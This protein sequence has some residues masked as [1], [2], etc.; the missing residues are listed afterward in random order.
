MAKHIRSSYGFMEMQSIYKMK[1]NLNSLLLFQA[2]GVIV[3]VEQIENDVYC[4]TAKGLY[5]AYRNY[6]AK[7]EMRYEYQ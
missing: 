7:G 4:V 2:N 6:N 5:Y 3:C 1:I